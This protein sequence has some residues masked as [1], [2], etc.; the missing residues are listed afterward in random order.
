MEVSIE[1]IEV[2]TENSKI[3]SEI[4]NE[5][6]NKDDLLSYE[7][8][9]G[10]ENQID[11]ETHDWSSE[12]QSE[13]RKNNSESHIESG[14]KDEKELTEKEQVIKK[15]WEEIKNCSIEDIEIAEKFYKESSSILYVPTSIECHGI[16]EINNA[17]SYKKQYRISSKDLSNEVVINTT[18]CGNIVI[19]EKIL[20]L[21]H[22]R[23]IKWLLPGVQAT[24]RRLVIPIVTIVTFDDDLYIKTKRVYWDQACVLKQVDLIPSILKCPYNGE[25][26]DLPVKGVQQSNP[27]LSK[28][29]LE[30]INN[31][32]IL[33]QTELNKKSIKRLKNLR[34]DYVNKNINDN[35]KKLLEDNGIGV[36]EKIQ[37]DGRRRSYNTLDFRNKSDTLSGF[38]S[39][40]IK[41]EYS[42]NERK[43][44]KNIIKNRNESKNINGILCE[45]DLTDDVSNRDSNRNSSISSRTRRLFKEHLYQ[46]DNIFSNSYKT[47]DELAF[48]GKR[49]FANRNRDDVKISMD[50]TDSEYEFFDSYS[51]IYDLDDNSIKKWDSNSLSRQTYSR[52]ETLNESNYDNQE[53]LINEKMKNLCL[54]NNYM[55]E[56]SNVSNHNL[57]D[58]NNKEESNQRK[59]RIHPYIKSSITFD[60][61]G[62]MDV[63]RQRHR[64][65]RK[66]VKP[67]HQS[68]FK[69]AYDKEELEKNNIYPRKYVSP[70]YIS[71]V[72]DND[73]SNDTVKRKVKPINKN[74]AFYE[75]Y[76]FDDVPEKNKVKSPVAIKDIFISNIFNDDV[77]EV[78]RHHNK[79]SPNIK[80][81]ITY[82]NIHFSGSG[83]EEEEEKKIVSKRFSNDF[84][85]KRYES[86]IFN[87]INQ[88]NSNE[89]VNRLDSINDNIDHLSSKEKKNKIS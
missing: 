1:D 46:N 19:E 36:D 42:M 17:H 25:D 65:G 40:D 37:H 24:G 30:N 57:N 84:S 6:E 67:H 62:N 28:E 76:M 69:I 50:K 23:P 10:S 29:Q 45:N 5:I 41:E 58:K 66:M 61:Y 71:H 53:D 55:D 73:N 38:V 35:V 26:T 86:N 87:S 44:N 7:K 83:D 79:F 18:V 34:S 9:N 3:H 78:Y 47:T 12:K 51:T 8:Y 4:I 13:D 15:R 43:S 20:T 74:S 16:E 89:L 85:K 2:Q 88:I 49:I 56:D 14:S 68:T 82:S 75:S 64:Y 63:N 32:D 21:L 52:D 39:G 33:N 31:M 27:L 48:S 70:T 72:F 80:N 54:H 81:Q 22:N 77:Q 59:H 11:Y 60:N